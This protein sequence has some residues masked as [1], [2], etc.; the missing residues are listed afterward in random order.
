M[1]ETG[2]T[3]CYVTDNADLI[4]LRG[5]LDLLLPK[6]AVVIKHLSDFALKWKDLPAVRNVLLFSY[7]ILTQSSR[8]ARIYSLP[9]ASLHSTL[10]GPTLKILILF[11]GL[12][13]SRSDDGHA[14][15]LKTSPWILRTSN[16]FDP[17]CDSGRC[18]QSRHFILEAEFWARTW[19]C[20]C[21]F[22]DSP[23]PPISFYTKYSLSEFNSGA[24]GTTGTQASFMEIFDNDGSKIDRLNEIIVREFQFISFL[25]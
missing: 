7:Y 13:W 9:T 24:Q 15:G 10:G 14:N 3:S 18:S 25:L 21:I 20:C 4:F 23:Y 19:V 8:T 2:A 16:W 17:L 12:S 22:F 1:R 6:L 5:G 11:L